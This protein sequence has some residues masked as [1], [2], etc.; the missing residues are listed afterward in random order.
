MA[1]FNLNWRLA[2]WILVAP[3]KTFFFQCTLICKWIY[4]ACWSVAT[5]W[6]PGPRLSRHWV[7]C[8]GTC[9]AQQGPQPDWHFRRGLACV[10][11]PLPDL[12][13][14]DYTTVSLFV[15]QPLYGCVAV[16]LLWGDW[17]VPRD[18][19]T[20]GSL[21]ASALSVCLWVVLCAISIP[22]PAHSE[23]LN[24]SGMQIFIL[25]HWIL[26]AQFFQKSKQKI[27]SIN[28]WLKIP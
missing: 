20:A 4:I 6:E 16:V 24:T 28:K 21:M 9:S 2:N 15:F 22:T 26:Y 18:E 3:G 17:D 8:Q 14:V 23:C 7:H 19:G 5:E 1:L 12:L 11:N 27:T 25:S 10:L 13:T